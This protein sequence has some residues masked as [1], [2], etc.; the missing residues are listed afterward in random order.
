MAISDS[1]LQELRAKIDIEQLVSPYTQLHRRGRMLMGLCPFHGERTPS[2]AVYP[3]N[4]SFYCFGCGAGGDA[5]SFVMRMDHLDYAEAVK[6]LSQQV[7]MR[8]PEDGYDDSLAQKRRRVL[9]ANREAARFFHHQLRVPSGQAGLQYWQSRKLTAE[10][11]THFGL[12]FAPDS[13]NALLTHM[14]AKGFS[15]DELVAANLITRSEK[16]GKTHHFDRFR[17]RVMVPIIDLRGN[18]VA[19]GGRV[20]DDSKPKYINTS[21]TLAYKK[22][23]DIYALPFAKNQ[24]NQGQLI[25]A[26]GYMDVIALHQA[27]YT[28]AVACLGT[29][30]T[31]EQAQLLSR[32]AKEVVLC[33]D[34]DEAG[35]TATKRALEVLG[36]TPLQLRV[37]KLSG[38]KD[39]DEILRIHGKARFQQLIDGAANEME[40]RLLQ[41]RGNLDL[42]TPAGKLS[43]LKAATAILANSRNAIEQDIYA[44]RLADELSVSKDAILEQV[45]QAVKR[46]SARRTRELQHELL[47]VQQ[48]DETKLDPQRMLHVAAAKAEERI[49]GLLLVS[50]ALFV[51]VQ[52]KL[53]AARF[54][55]PFN[56]RLAEQLFA[57]LEAGRGVEPELLSGDLTPQELSETM[58]MRL[59]AAPIQNVTEEFDAC[60]ER[61][62]LEH[63]KLQT[64][65]VDL[66]DDEAFVRLF[67]QRAK[68]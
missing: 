9:D 50:P 10:T 7:G 5:I 32:Y 51:K 18:V 41:A 13:W 67:N 68:G 65:N 4:N 19:F 20:L 6:S 25:L 60:V 31:K 62:Q 38:G 8:L 1:Y 15:L 16:N 53:S 34:A 11:I 47:Q 3:E 56:Q 44:S 21:D 27:G 66:T 48:K 37:L 33:Y 28:N 58:R 24:G 43:F 40:Y 57:R 30:L 46:E 49:L 52:G 42:T 55:T 45:R 2:F 12:G 22:G 23:H 26:E 39:P 63:A 64:Q 14:C 36:K 29:A 35:Q 54:V 59:L 17:G 61:L